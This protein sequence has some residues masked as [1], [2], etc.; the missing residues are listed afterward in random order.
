VV[1]RAELI[2]QTTAMVSRREQQ[3]L[4]LSAAERVMRIIRV[5]HANEKPIALD[6]VV[7]PLSRLPN[8]A[9][10]GSAFADLLEVAQE[11]GMTLGLARERIRTVRAGTQVAALLQTRTGARLLKLDRITFTADGIPIEW[12]I[13]Y[14]VPQV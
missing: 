3:Q 8:L 14:S 6:K 7:L 5:R 1:V 13:S 4:G 12:R 9:R 10:N 11:H 2:G